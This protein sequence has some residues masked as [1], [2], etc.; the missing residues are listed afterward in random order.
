MKLSKRVILVGLATVLS[1]II[2]SFASIGIYKTYQGLFPSYDTHLTQKQ[3]VD[4]VKSQNVNLVFYKVG[5]PYCQAG[6]SSVVSEA[7]KSSYTTFYINVDTTDGQKLVS[8]YQVEKAATIVTIR[9]G[10]FHSFIYAKDSG[11]N[12]VADDKTINKAFRE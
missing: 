2:L 12:I 10:E 6:K 3:Y 9:E 7:K 1:V 8:Q 5:C 11:K 4:T